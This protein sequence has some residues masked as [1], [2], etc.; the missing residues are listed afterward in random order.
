MALSALDVP[1]SDQ[2]Q[3]FK[4]L[5]GTVTDRAMGLW[6]PEN[7]C[8]TAGILRLGNITFEGSEASRIV[9]TNGNEPSPYY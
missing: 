7:W 4:T 8:W 1:I 9:N 5:S 2:E 3:V 6:F